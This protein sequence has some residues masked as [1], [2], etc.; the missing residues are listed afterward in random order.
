MEELIERLKNC[1]FCPHSCGVN[2]FKETGFCR[3]PVLYRRGELYLKIN[4]FQ[5]FFFEEPVITGEYGSGNIFFSHCNLRCVFC[6]NFDISQSGD[7]Y[8]ISLSRLKEIIIGLNAKGCQFINLVT[9]TP[10][11]PLILSVIK[12]IKYQQKNIRFVYNTN[13]YET[14]EIIDELSGWID[15]F[16][17]DYKY[18]QANL[19]EIYSKISNYP[20]TAERA[21]EKM[22]AATGRFVMDD[23]GLM[24]SGVIVRHLVLPGHL[25]SSKEILTF[26]TRNFKDRILVSLMAQYTPFAL[27]KNYEM[28]NRPLTLDEYE[29]IK[30]Y[31]ISLNAFDLFCQDLDSADTFYIPEFYHPPAKKRSDL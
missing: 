13:G 14:P 4:L 25:D 10:Y 12:A 11:A 23:M 27:A 24:R 21:I 7:G 9:P 17:P 22:V 2:R 16:L 1:N 6:Q 29:L 3:A 19:A 20:K 5:P 31:A 18:S 15:I 28:I 8:Y 26:L 30:E